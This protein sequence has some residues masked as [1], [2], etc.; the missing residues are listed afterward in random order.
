LQE[1][2][3]VFERGGGSLVVLRRPADMTPLDA[4]GDTGDAKA[5]MR[6]IKQQLDP[7]GTLN[8]GRFAG[9]I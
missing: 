8:P 6:A 9:G 4:W 7:R 3:A 1:L 2:R 5:V